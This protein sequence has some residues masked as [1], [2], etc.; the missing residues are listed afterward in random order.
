MDGEEYKNGKAD[1]ENGSD[2]S[3]VQVSPEDAQRMSSGESPSPP[4]RDSPQ[5]ISGSGVPPE[6]EFEE[7]ERDT[8]IT[9]N[10]QVL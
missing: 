3:Y 1:S 5:L 10:P 8:T 7:G 9:D 4:M 6:E 2:N